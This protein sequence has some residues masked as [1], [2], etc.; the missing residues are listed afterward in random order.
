[1]SFDDTL[2][3]LTEVTQMGRTGGRSN[4]WVLG[5]DLG[6]LLGSSIAT[7][8]LGLLFLRHTKSVEGEIKTH[9]DQKLKA[10]EST[11]AWREQMLFELLGPVCMQLDRT[12]RAFHRWNGKNLGLES[13]VIREG[14]LTIRDL[15]LAKGHLIP[16]EL[17]EDAAQLIEHYD[18]WLLKFDEVRAD[19][20]DESGPA[21]VFVGPDGYPF[22]HNAEAKFKHEFRVVQSELYGHL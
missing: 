12:K 7:M 9:F 22:P 16:P 13:K 6:G 15:L 5:S 3:F 10:F 4:G 1:M 19:S 11:R 8:M 20:S 2:T 17:Q 14:N 21:F 18:A